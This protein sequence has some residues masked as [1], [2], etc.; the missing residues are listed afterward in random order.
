M[1]DRA[2]SAATVAEAVCAST[3][4]NANIAAT[5]AGSVC[6]SMGADA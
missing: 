2:I 3:G 6:V 1:V 5:V 4:A